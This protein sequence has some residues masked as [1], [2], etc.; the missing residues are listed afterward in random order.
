MGEILAVDAYLTT[1]SGEMVESSFGGPLNIRVRNGKV[2]EKHSNQSFS[3]RRLFINIKF[4]LPVSHSLIGGRK[5]AQ[6]ARM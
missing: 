6:K 1:A 3:E 4:L 2:E 5:E